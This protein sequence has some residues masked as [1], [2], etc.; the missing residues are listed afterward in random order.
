M[1][2]WQPGAQPAGVEIV[3]YQVI[4]ERENPLRVFSVDLPA[5]TTS[6]TIPAEFLEPGT[7]YK[8]EVLAI[9]AS[10]NQTITEVEFTTMQPRLGLVPDHTA[11]ANEARATRGPLRGE[12]SEQSSP[13]VAVGLPCD[14]TRD[15]P[16]PHGGTP[17]DR[18]GRGRLMA[19]CRL[20]ESRVERLVLE[21]EEGCVGLVEQLREEPTARGIV[22]GPAT[23]DPV[24]IPRLAIVERELDPAPGAPRSALER[25]DRPF[26]PRPRRA[27]V[28]WRGIAVTYT[29]QD[30]GLLVGGEGGENGQQ[31]AASSRR[32]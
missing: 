11:T 32:A 30:G 28:V 3:S 15:Q 29:G 6:V 31:P 26:R 2:S 25:S 7:Q 27:L 18:H 5:T 19:G 21:P 4:V 22:V 16:A 23:I 17:G 10:G 8:V 12:V 1:I 20:D 9:E 13:W 14:P 24:R